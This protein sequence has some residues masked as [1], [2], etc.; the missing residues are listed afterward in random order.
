MF[1]G[2]VM[3][4]LEGTDKFSPDEKGRDYLFPQRW[5]DGFLCPKCQ[6][7]K[8]WTIQRSERTAPVYECTQCHHQTSV[9]AGTIF[10]R[11]KVALRIWFMA[12]FMVGVDKRGKSALALSHELHLRYVTAWL[13]HHKIQQVMAD[14][15]RRYQLGGLL[16]LDDAYFGGISHGVGKQGRGT[17]QDP[18]IV[19]VSLD[20]KGHP[21]YAFL[22]AVPDLKNETIA[23]VLNRRVEPLGV[24]RTDGLAG[25]AAAAKTH[26]A[27]HEVTYSDDPE[28]AHVFRWVNT[29]ISN[30][31]AMIDG[32]F[33][34]RG[35]ARRQLYLEEFAYRFNRRHFGTR[36]ADRLLV[37]CLTTTPHPY[38][39]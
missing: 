35:R 1:G 26:H 34:G 21:L 17:D 7:Q 15:N 25:Y 16:E 36:I 31:K 5:P 12:I 32:T 33:H 27:D 39:T 23:E 8:C 14:R 11:T 38:G 4:I 19:G 3:P 13:L 18:V 20:G 30:A 24:W 28:A 22:E 29:T 9:T 37:A 10:H 6:G 2:V